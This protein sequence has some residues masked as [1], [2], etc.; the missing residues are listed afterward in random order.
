MPSPDTPLLNGKPPPK[1]SPGCPQ[2][3]SKPATKYHVT[4]D[5]LKDVFP[6]RLV[7][8][9]RSQ[10]NKKRLGV[11]DKMGD[12]LVYIPFELFS[13]SQKEKKSTFSLDWRMTIKSEDMP[14]RDKSKSKEFILRKFD[15]PDDRL[16]QFQVYYSVLISTFTERYGSMPVVGV[17]CCDSQERLPR[18][19]MEYTTEDEFQFIG[20]C[21]T[22]YE[23]MFRQPHQKY[24]GQIISA[25]HG[26]ENP[27]TVTETTAPLNVASSNSGDFP[28]SSVASDS[29]GTLLMT[30][31]TK[32]SIT[33]CQPPLNGSSSGEQPFIEVRMDGN[34]NGND[35]NEFLNKTDEQIYAIHSDEKIFAI[36]AGKHE[37]IVTKYIDHVEAQEAKYKEYEQKLNKFEHIL[38]TEKKLVRSTR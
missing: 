26:L 15:V 21:E 27:K 36:F 32:N 11:I 25:L 34:N 14:G 7:D 10:K 38:D 30:F 18:V 1:Y 6:G 4:L 29:S 31:N 28:S 13:T 2:N 17:T 23:E 8:K 3:K 33:D 12:Y 16:R 19:I 9:A 22:I 35:F 24:I 5:E 37:R 20:K